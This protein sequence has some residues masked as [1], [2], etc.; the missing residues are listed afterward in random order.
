[1]EHRESTIHPSVVSSPSRPTVQFI[2]EKVATDHIGVPTCPVVRKVVV[3]CAFV[4]FKFV[5]CK[6][7]LMCISLND[8]I[9][10]VW[11]C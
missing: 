4:C 10:V 2:L 6:F 9:K 5:G 8:N 11:G 7:T 1:M 3:Q